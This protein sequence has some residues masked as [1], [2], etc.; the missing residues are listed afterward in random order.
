MK[1]DIHLA[2][3]VISKASKKELYV[4]FEKMRVL[5]PEEWQEPCL[6]RIYE[7]IYVDKDLK[8]RLIDYCKIEY[9]NK[10]M[11]SQFQTAIPLDPKRAPC[12]YWMKWNE[13]ELQIITKRANQFFCLLCDLLLNNYRRDTKGLCQ[14]DHTEW[15]R[16]NYLNA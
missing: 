8:E 13:K 16:L 12:D 1:I 3:I 14:W 15:F 4:A 10:N 2:Q 6:K 7:I 11:P 5:M 9:N